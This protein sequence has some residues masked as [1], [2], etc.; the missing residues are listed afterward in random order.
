[1]PLNTRRVA[2][3]VAA[4]LVDTDI[5]GLIIR[6]ERRLR[7]IADYDTPSQHVLP[8]NRGT[9]LIWR[10]HSFTRFEERDGG[11]YIEIEVV[12]LSRDIPAALRWMIWQERR[13]SR[14]WSSLRPNSAIRRSLPI[15]GDQ[16]AAVQP[17][18]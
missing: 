5:R 4:V 11:V 8:E 10:L 9:R 3:A 17:L 16:A 7:E 1:M 13:K 2:D 14:C 15:N 12:A 18:R 6:I